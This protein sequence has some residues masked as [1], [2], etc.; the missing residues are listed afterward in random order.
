MRNFNN[1]PPEAKVRR[2]ELDLHSWFDTIQGEGPFTGQRAMFIRL[3]GC[4]IQCP[5]CDTEYTNGRKLHSVDVIT[6]MLATYVHPMCKLFV[7][8]GGEPF[9]Q[10]ATTSLILALIAK[11]ECKIQVETNGVFG[12]PQDLWHFL[13]NPLHVVVSPKTNRIHE[14]CAR[15]S[16][17]KYVIDHKSVREEDGLPILALGHKASPYIA[18]PPAEFDGP[19]YV[20]PADER[21]PVADKANLIAARDSA[22]KH[23]Y[24]LGVQLHKLVNV[25]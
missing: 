14:S 15:A 24:I 7:I 2:E 22:F 1:Q 5:G 20:N 4:N 19:I 6:E 16:A 25:P 21:D 9:R 17:F 23:G 11:T 3:A 10:S 13:G 12:I 18:R 8:T